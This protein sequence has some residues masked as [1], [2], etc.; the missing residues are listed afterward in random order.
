[1]KHRTWI[2]LS[3]KALR[4][5][6][7]QVHQFCDAALLG[8]VVKANA[9]GHG[10][11]QIAELLEQHLAVQ[12]LF[13]AGTSEAIALRKQGIQ[14]PI[15]AMSCLDSSIDEVIAYDIACAVYTCE[16][17]RCLSDIACRLGKVARI[18]V[19]IDS[20]MSR[21]GINFHE[22]GQ[23]LDEMMNMPGLLVEGIFTHLC[24]TNNLDST[25]TNEQLK[26]FDTVIACNAVAQKI[27]YRHVIASGSLLC[28]KKYDV[29]RAGTN[30]YGFWKSALQK[31]RFLA[32]IPGMTLEPVLTWKS[33]IM[34]IKSITSSLGTLMKLALI[35]VGYYD[36][37]PR[38]ATGFVLVRGR[39]A[40]IVGLVSMDMMKINVIN[41]PDAQVEDEVILLGD[42]PGVTATDIADSVGTINN[43]VV[44]R[45]HVDVPRLVIDD[46]PKES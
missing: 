25:F 19:K 28:K 39:L 40:P 43:E 46:I 31:E 8:V 18:H 6:I 26:I 41:I 2:E 38:V 23:F 4:H 5:N 36:G 12:W 20:N 7:T 44:T 15:L 45:I 9:Y 3:K 1:M 14:K 32:A 17:A 22:V 24:D 21:L 27:R 10:M 13:V 11:L 29:V 16:A 34:Q 37:Y 35:P 30:I 33:R 42:H